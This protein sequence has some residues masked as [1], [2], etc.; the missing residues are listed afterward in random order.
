MKL[1]SATELIKLSSNNTETYV[2][3]HNVKIR[4]AH[5]QNQNIKLQDDIIK[6]NNLHVDYHNALEKMEQL[7]T[8]ENYAE[9]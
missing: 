1:V 6:N 4:D 9:W 2:K 7:F 8:L 5:L 3:D